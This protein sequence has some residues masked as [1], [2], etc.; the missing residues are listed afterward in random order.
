V[1]AAHMIYLVR[2]GGDHFEMRPLDFYWPFLFLATVEGVLVTGAAC[3]PWLEKV[4]SR[5]GPRLRLDM[6]AV[7]ATVLLGVTVVYGFA[8]QQAK[9]LF[10]MPFETRAASHFLIV[11]LQRSSSPWLFALPGM[12]L[13]IPAYDDVQHYALLH[14]VGTVWREH[15]VF[16]RDEIKNWKPYEITRGRGALPPDSVTARGSIGVSGYYLADL[17]MVDQK[18][19]TD[20]LVAHSG[21]DLPNEKRYMAH[22]RFA[23]PD[24]I[25]ERGFNVYVEPAATNLHAALLAGPFALQLAHDTWMPFS[26]RLPAWVDKAFVGRPLWKWTTAAEV[27]CF[28]DGVDSG[29]TFDGDAFTAGVRN[30]VPRTRPIQWFPRCANDRGLLSRDPHEGGAGTGTARSP[31]FHVPDGAAL[32]LRVFGVASP[33]TSVRVIDRQ[34]DA[35]ATFH[36]NETQAAMIEHVDLAPWSGR[37]MRV[38]LVDGTDDSWVGALGIVMLAPQ[39]LDGG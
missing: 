7:A 29:W 6:G 26:S 10:T 32:E 25:F 4:R 11:D 31:W 5:L 34:G 33:E 37:E 16:W 22:D 1:I 2:I 12:S 24:Y 21:G 13:L 17:E 15:E 28:K 30:D 9:Y 20:R 19:L 39:P 18:G 27:G 3:R 38:E 14:G 35:I 36:P 23:Q 8:V